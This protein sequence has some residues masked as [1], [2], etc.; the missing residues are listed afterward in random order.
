MLFKRITKLI[1]C[2]HFKNLIKKKIVC[3]AKEYPVYVN[4]ILFML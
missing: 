3:E 1:L 2:C 4:Q